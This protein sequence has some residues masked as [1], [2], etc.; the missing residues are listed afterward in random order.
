MLIA[1][2]LAYGVLNSPKL[3]NLLS[4]PLAFMPLLVFLLPDAVLVRTSEI[5]G[6][7]PVLSERFAD[8]KESINLFLDNLPLGIGANG[9]IVSDEYPTFNLI[10]GIACRFGVVALLLFVAI[11]VLR[12][13][14]LSSY[15]AFYKNS[16]VGPLVNM[17]SLSIY[18]FIVF[19]MFYDLFSHTSLFC[20][21][22]SMLGI[23]SATLR[24]SKSAFDDYV[25]YYSDLSRF[26]SADASIILATK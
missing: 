6:I 25:S 1:V 24:I 7:T 15:S 20:L 17:S 5:F 23:C 10:T 14:H 8:I 3:V 9:L 11:L 26:D 21:F 13:L 22:W 18:C 4:I 2:V 16:S 19:G 12:L